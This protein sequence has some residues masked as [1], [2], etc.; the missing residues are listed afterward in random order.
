MAE[1]VFEYTWLI[2]QLQYAPSEDGLENVIKTINWRLRCKGEDN[3]SAE[4]YGTV[5]LDSPNPEG[6]EAFESLTKEQVVEWLVAALD[7][8]QMS[9]DTPY[10]ETLKTNLKNQ[11]IKTRNPP[12]IGTSTMPW[13]S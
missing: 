7:K 6:F 8:S 1:E 11:I 4:C 2:E 12:V 5:G 10:S 9:S 3:L 13:D